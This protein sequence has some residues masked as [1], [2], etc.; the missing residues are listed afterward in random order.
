MKRIDLEGFLEDIERLD[1]ENLIV[2]GSLA[3]DEYSKV[4]DEDF[5]VIFEDL[6]IDKLVELRKINEEYEYDLFPLPKGALANVSTYVISPIFTKQFNEYAFPLMG[7]QRRI[8]TPT[9]SEMK[10]N[11]IYFFN[12]AL[13]PIRFVFSQHPSWTEKED[14]IGEAVRFLDWSL[15][16][17]VR[18]YLSYNGE[19]PTTRRDMIKRLK[20][21]GRDV[22]VYEKLMEFRNNPKDALGSDEF[23]KECINEIEKFDLVESQE[24]EFKESEGVSR[25]HPLEELEDEEWIKSIILYG[26]RAV[27]EAKEK[28]DYDY[29]VVAD[30]LDL[31]KLRKMGRISEEYEEEHKGKISILPYAL[32]EMRKTRYEEIRK[33]ARIGKIRFFKHSAYS[34][35]KTYKVMCGF[36]VL[37]GLELEE[38]EIEEDA[39]KE[40]ILYKLKMPKKFVNGSEAKTLPKRCIWMARDY[41]FTRGKFPVTKAEIMEGMEEENEEM[42]RR[43]LDIRNGEEDVGLKCLKFARDFSL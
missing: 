5:L 24:I 3:T 26:S 2:Y 42:Y 17:R 37:E 40:F 23:F 6:E 22:E 36:D 30:E 8:R 43:L 1:P 13:L 35:K 4:S 34:F 32:E 16:G 41:L 14:K 18:G 15:F 29:L 9:E 38:P 11:A 31:E 27:G 21:R 25:E 39:K 33:G 28:S 12:A 10:K 7:E 19:V 20:E